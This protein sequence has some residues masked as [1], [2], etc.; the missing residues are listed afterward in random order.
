[1][2]AVGIGATTFAAGPAVEEMTAARSFEVA[3]AVDPAA[4]VAAATKQFAAQP[5]D[6]A[7]VTKKFEAEVVTM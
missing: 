6:F 3:V 5:V 2:A 1:M 4:E 7:T